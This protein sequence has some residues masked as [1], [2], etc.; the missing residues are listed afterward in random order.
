MAAQV[1]SGNTSTGENLLYTNNTGQNVRLV[2]NFIMGSRLTVKWGGSSKIE[3]SWSNLISYGKYLAYHKQ[4]VNAGS[5]ANNANYWA[6]DGPVDALPLE[7][8]LAN[9]HTFE[10][11]QYAPLDHDLSHGRGGY[12]ILVV[13]ESG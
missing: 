12:N 4:D 11:E 13:P 10:I 2:I 6:G 7:I 5:H 1:L 3:I 8:P 9:G